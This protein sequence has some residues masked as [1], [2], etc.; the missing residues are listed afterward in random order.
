[1]E[2]PAPKFRYVALDIEVYSPSNK[3][4]RPREAAYPVVCVSLYSSD[5]QKRVLLLKR[6][7]VREGAERL[8]ADVKIEYFDSE[9]KLIR[10]VF[11]VL[12]SY[13]SL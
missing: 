11:E 9:E 10:A 2:Y 4:A 3:N 1:L 7:G 5:G 8:P 13:P 12:W 6:E